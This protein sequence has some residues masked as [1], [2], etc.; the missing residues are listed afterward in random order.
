ME[1]LLAC[2]FCIIMGAV[3]G[4][5]MSRE[6]VTVE[7]RPP[8]WARERVKQIRNLEG[9]F[10]DIRTHELRAILEDTPARYPQLIKF[11]RIYMIIGRTGAANYMPHCALDDAYMQHF[12]GVFNINALALQIE[13]IRFMNGEDIYTRDE[14]RLLANYWLK[15]AGILPLAETG[16]RVG[17]TGIKYETH[18]W[19]DENGIEHRASVRT[20]DSTNE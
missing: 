2:A 17:A 5:I 19:H 8:A 7:R 9:S 14:R 10:A 1:I 11:I 16:Y 6:R 20:E 15:T 4:L 13:L 3:C 12:L 18:A